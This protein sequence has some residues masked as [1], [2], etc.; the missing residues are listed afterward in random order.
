MKLI[1][2]ANNDRLDLRV[3]EHLF[4]AAISHPRLVQ[5]S[6]FLAQVISQIANGVKLRIA[7][8]AARIE[9]RDLGNGAAAEDA[10]TQETLLFLNHASSGY[11]CR[12]ASRKAVSFL[13]AASAASSR[14]CR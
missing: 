1:G 8:L 10:D 5:S 13:A 9:V 6:H 11:R 2:H 12:S 3:G 4:I 7:R 14:A